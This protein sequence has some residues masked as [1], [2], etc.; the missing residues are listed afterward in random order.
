MQTQI[1]KEPIS[2]V[3]QHQMRFLLT[4]IINSRWE[5]SPPPGPHKAINS[6]FQKST[7][8]LWLLSSDMQA[9]VAHGSLSVWLEKPKDSHVRSDGVMLLLSNLAGA[10]TELLLCLHP[11]H[12]ALIR[13]PMTF[14]VCSQVP[15]A[16]GAM[17]GFWVLFCL[18]SYWALLRLSPKRWCYH[19][20]RLQCPVNLRSN[21]LC[22]PWGQRWYW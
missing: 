8:L 3:Q 1:S 19:D 11:Q 10:P 7:L 12:L 16:V 9:I 15:K 17:L 4:M 2:S 18:F 6:R 22:C 5:I 13:W 14:F 21:K 20:R